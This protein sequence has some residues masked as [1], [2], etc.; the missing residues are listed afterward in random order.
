MKPYRARVAP[1]SQKQ[2]A[3]PAEKNAWT[4][5]RLACEILTEA[6]KEKFYLDQILERRLAQTSL[7]AADRALVT[8]LTHGVMRARARLDVELI[9]HFRKNYETAPAHLRN[10][11]RTALFQM[12]FMDRIPA[13]A[14]I[15]EAVALVREKLGENLARLCNAVLRSAQRAPYVWPPVEDVLAQDDLPGLSG[16]LSYPEWLIVRWLAQYG[17]SETLA[18]AQACNEIP[19]LHLR[20]VHPDQNTET[21]L[22]ELRRERIAYAP[23]PQVPEVYKLAHADQI[24]AL[25]SFRNGAC[26][27]QDASTCLVASLAAPKASETI[28]DLC[29][30]P[31]G[32]ALHLAELAA[33]GKV[34]AIDLRAQRLRLLVA[35][36]QRMKLCVHA[37]VSDARYF[38]ASPADVVLVDAP[39]SGLG[40]LGRRSDLRWRRK[41]E[42]IPLL[43]HLQKEILANAAQLVKIGGRLIY[44]T[45]T[46]APEENEEIVAW[47]LQEH[48][49]F[50][51]QPAR[52]FLPASF[53]DESGFVRT[54]PH[55]HGMD[56]SFAARFM[57]AS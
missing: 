50:L 5:R 44:S 12:R 54:W 33:P 11:L 22:R 13:Y 48:P 15:H 36:A 52:D 3:P 2:P 30:A 51:L 16:S 23:V 7:P 42:D 34:I 40:V 46:I 32:K 29:A 55:R 43:V 37:L 47:F 4:A 35:A 31:G 49:L 6:E 18:L 8:A 21:V 38:A 10:A 41:P 39:C 45:C 1:T 14:A 53:C 9:Q 24:A 57:K 17:A 28:I 25:S 27:V 26:T 19:D 20:V 56:G